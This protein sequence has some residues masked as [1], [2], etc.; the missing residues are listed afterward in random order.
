MAVHGQNDHSDSVLLLMANDHTSPTQPLHPRARRR[1]AVIAGVAA[2]VVLGLAYIVVVTPSDHG[3]AEAQ[4]TVDRATAECWIYLIET[5]QPRRTI[6]PWWI[7]SVS[8]Q[9]FTVNGIGRSYDVRL[10]E[11]LLTTHGF[12]GQ[13]IIGST[14]ECSP[15]RRKLQPGCEDSFVFDGQ[16]YECGPSVPFEEFDH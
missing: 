11:G 10:E 8:P 4:E 9:S 14:G 15:L 12:N 5:H 16:R 13:T 3:V 6:G 2:V 1:S 7:S